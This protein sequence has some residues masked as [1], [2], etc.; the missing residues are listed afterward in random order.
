MYD[1][2]NKIDRLMEELIS[3]TYF[4]NN[5]AVCTNVKIDTI[6]KSLIKKTS[7]A[8]K[9]EWEHN[10]IR[11]EIIATFYEALLICSNDYDY[12]DITLDNS[13]LIG[14]AYNYTLQKIKKYL[15]SD[16]LNNKISN[17]ADL[18]INY[19]SNNNFIIWF[20]NYKKLFL[21]QKQLDFLDNKIIYDDP[22]QNR[23]MRRRIEDRVLR[24]YNTLHNKNNKNIDMI[25]QKEIIENLLESNDFFEDIKEY[26]DSDFFNNI[27]TDY[28]DLEA[29]KNYYEGTYNA[30]TKKAFR[31]AL[32]K[33]LNEIN[34]KYN[35]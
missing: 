21:T 3:V 14:S 35:S 17:E 13:K 28:L 12:D 9:I 23:K 27:W 1:K 29:R 19:N 30:N 32:F 20:N 16:N 24:N 2:K 33:K 26:V 15:L 34:N 11:D 18:N 25:T 7:Y 4:E 5:N 6:I 22:E 8:A 31:V 10:I